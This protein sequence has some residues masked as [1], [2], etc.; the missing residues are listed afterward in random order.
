MTLKRIQDDIFVYFYK[1]RYTLMAISRLKMLGVCAV[2]TKNCISWNIFYPIMLFPF[3]MI[4]VYILTLFC[5]KIVY[6]FYLIVNSN[7]N[8]DYIYKMTEAKLASHQYRFFFW[9]LRIFWGWKKLAPK[10]CWGVRKAVN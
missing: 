4:S 9:G 2:F 5:K 1:Y 8:I 7:V 10:F 6:T 3:C